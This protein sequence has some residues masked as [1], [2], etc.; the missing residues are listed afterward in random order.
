MFITDDLSPA[1]LLVELLSLRT[2]SSEQTL[3]FQAL[4][5][6]R[7]LCPRFADQIDAMLDVYKR[8]RTDVHDIQGVRDSGVDV[9][10]QFETENNSSYKVGIQLK[11]FRELEDA[12]KGH[13]ASLF[14]VL[15]SQY[16][17]ATSN[18]G[19]DEWLLVLCTDEVQHSNAIR[20]ICSEFKQVQKAKII[21]PRQALAFYELEPVELASRVSSLL[22]TEDLILRKARDEVSHISYIA[23]FMLLRLTSGALRGERSVSQ[24]AIQQLYSD[25][26]EEKRKYVVNEVC[27]EDAEEDE[28]VFEDEYADEDE[29]DRDLSEQMSLIDVL[30]ELEHTGVLQ[31]DG[32]IGYDVRPEELPGVCALYF[33]QAIR[34]ELDS[35]ELLPILLFKIVKVST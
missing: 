34:S 1:A 27:D 22:C 7:D 20:A 11:S 14:Q 23:L 6:N 32:G 21:K 31:M 18:L 8:H 28:G 9:L 19:V 17:E 24:Q 10:L 5:H 30:Q 2:R 29:N 12:R 33:D 13:G 4:R 26:E 35:T 15:K 3:K 25:W 16:L